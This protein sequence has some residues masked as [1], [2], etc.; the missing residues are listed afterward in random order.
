MAAMALTLDVSRRWPLLIALTASAVGVAAFGY[1]ACY[2]LWMT[3][4]QTDAQLV[5]LWRRRFG[6]DL[7]ACLISAAVAL[8]LVVRLVRIRRT[9]A[10]GK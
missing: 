9:P 2:G 8:I 1:R 7:G 4:Y 5:G 10:P 3:A 6:L